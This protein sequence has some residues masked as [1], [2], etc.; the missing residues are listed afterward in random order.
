LLCRS[1]LAWCSPFCSLLLLDAESFEF[2]LRSCS[3]YLSVPVFFL[4]L[5]RAVSKFQ[6]LY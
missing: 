5:S 6:A 1:S 3:L 4:L 2:C